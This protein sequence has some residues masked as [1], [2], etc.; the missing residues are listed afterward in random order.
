MSAPVVDYFAPT[1]ID[2]SRCYWCQGQ[3]ADFT[4]VYLTK[5]RTCIITDAYICRSCQRNC[6]RPITSYLARSRI[7]TSPTFVVPRHTFCCHRC[8]QTQGFPVLL[9]D[10]AESGACSVCP[11]DPLDTAE[12]YAK[13]AVCLRLH[14][15]GDQLQGT[16]AVCAMCT[17]KKAKESPSVPRVVG[18]NVRRKCMTSGCM[19]SAT[20]MALYES[21]AMACSDCAIQN[22]HVSMYALQCGCAGA[23]RAS[24]KNRPRLCFG[25][26]NELVPRRCVFC[27][28]SGDVDLTNTA[29]RFAHFFQESSQVLLNF[30]VVSLG[31]A[32]AIVALGNGKLNCLVVLLPGHDLDKFL[33]KIDGNITET[34]TAVCVYFINAYSGDGKGEFVT[35]M[36]PS[37]HA[38]HFCQMLSRFKHSLPAPDSV[39]L[40]YSTQ[41]SIKCIDVPG[42]KA[43]QFLKSH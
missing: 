41:R 29:E 5:Y 28:E 43:S 15:L 13:C 17:A 31:L 3:D 34:G 16:V 9:A 11:D 30:K 33:D 38:R 42:R 32:T 14:P 27:R 40:Q 23:L 18:P 25:R 36:I 1:I 20:Q 4:T 12:K 2:N 8:H 7:K 26:R 39:F 19:R 37:S 10:G 6:S 24:R 35:P 22:V 21:E